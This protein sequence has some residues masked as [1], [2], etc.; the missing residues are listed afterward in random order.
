MRKLDSP[1]VSKYV[2]RYIVVVGIYYLCKTPHLFHLT[3][4]GLRQFNQRRSGPC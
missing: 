2:P 4:K 1:L 3:M